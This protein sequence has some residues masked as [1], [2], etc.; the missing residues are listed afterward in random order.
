MDTAAAAGA[1][2]KKRMK[3]LADAE[4]VLVDDLGV[5]PLLFF[6]YHNIVSSKLKGWEDNVM[7]FHLSR[8]IDIER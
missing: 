3:L 4:K 2:P 1:D 7:D 8:F 6:S 5:M